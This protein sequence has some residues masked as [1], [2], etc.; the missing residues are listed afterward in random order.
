MSLVWPDTRAG[1][2][3]RV[4]SG[5]YSFKGWFEPWLPYFEKTTMAPEKNHNGKNFEIEIFVSKYVLG[6]FESSPIKKVFRP[7]KFLSLPFFRSMPPIFRKMAMSPKKSQNGKKF[8]NRDFHSKIRFGPFWNDS[9]LKKFLAKKFVIAIFS[10]FNPH[11]SKKWL[12]PLRKVITGIFF[13]IEIFVL[14]YVLDHS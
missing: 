9:D 12:C 11:F 13:K 5:L 3:A 10:T 7:K 1:I 2:G 8:R 4:W 14:K 6:H